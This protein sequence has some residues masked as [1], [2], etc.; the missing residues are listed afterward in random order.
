MSHAAPTRR[1]LAGLAAPGGLGP[2]SASTV[3]KGG[4]LLLLVV[5]S[6]VTIWSPTWAVAVFYAALVVVLLVKP[7]GF[8]GR[9]EV[10]AQ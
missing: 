2:V 7:T 10:R 6:L 5:E 1:P 9:K 8:F 3:A 4:G